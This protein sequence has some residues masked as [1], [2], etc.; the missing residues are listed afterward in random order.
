M[1]TSVSRTRKCVGALHEGG[2][3]HQQNIM[4]FTS[5]QVLLRRDKTIH[6]LLRGSHGGFTGICRCLILAQIKG[7]SIFHLGVI[8]PCQDDSCHILI[9]R[10]KA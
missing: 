10:F 7:T 5:Y 1:T 4:L 2:T 6:L 8:R 3:G 9:R